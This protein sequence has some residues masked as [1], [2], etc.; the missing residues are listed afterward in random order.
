MPKK[1]TRSRGWCFTLQSWTIEDFS[2]A[3]CLYEYDDNAEY[4]IVGFE[5]APR[6][7]REHLQCYIYYKN[8][9]SWNQM[10]KRLP[11]VHFQAQKSAKNVKAYCYCMEDYHYCEWGNRPRQGHRTDLEVIKCDLLSKKKDIK[12][13]S[14]DNFSQYCQYSRQFKTFVEMH[15]LDK[16]ETL[17]IVYN[18]ATIKNIYRD[19]A[20]D[21]YRSLIFKDSYYLKMDLLHSYYSGRYKYIFIPNSLGVEEIDEVDK[22]LF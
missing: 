13:V 21:L 2:I 9:V 4:L 10:K 6:T 15:N 18:D 14:T 3:A 17:L 11:G 19:Y 16:Y 12:A 8:Q 20:D 22:V 1:D 7:L 5:I